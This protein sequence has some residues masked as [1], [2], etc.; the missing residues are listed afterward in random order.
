MSIINGLY[1]V[2]K[3]DIEQITIQLA[4]ESHPI[5]KAHFPNHPILPG[6]ALIDIVAKVLNDTIVNI[7]YS[8]FISHLEPNDIILCT[9]KTNADQRS[10][11]IFKNKK[12]V[13][14]ILYET[15]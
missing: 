12:K 7:Q 4:T 6:F 1:T 11:K 3:Q 9:I 15:K 14:E 5:F 13:S 8:K 10:I 2:L